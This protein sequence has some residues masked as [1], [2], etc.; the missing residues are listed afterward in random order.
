M[1]KRS[2]FFSAMMNAIYLFFTSPHSER[3][4][5]LS[6]G[7]EAGTRIKKSRVERFSVDKASKTILP[8]AWSRA[9]RCHA[10]RSLSR[11]SSTPI[12]RHL[13]SLSRVAHATSMLMAFREAK[14]CQGA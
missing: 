2:V 13:G 5:K 6:R 14:P 9:Q 1:S 11:P 3:T 7:G 10:L 12:S 8:A 4:S